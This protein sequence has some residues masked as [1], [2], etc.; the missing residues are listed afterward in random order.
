MINQEKWLHTIQKN[1]FKTSEN[2]EQL[3]YYRWTNTIP[4]KKNYSSVK[5]YSVVT[6]LLVFGFL[7]VSV[8][9]NETRNL[10]KEI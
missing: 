5:K 8:I 6:I 10:Q 9:K 4:K 2:K 7:F 1:N 3:D